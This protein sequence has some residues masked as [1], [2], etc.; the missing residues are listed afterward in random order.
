MAF[1]KAGLLQ[2]LPPG[3]AIQVEAGADA[4]AV[5]NVGGTLYAIDGICPHSGGPLGY[6][7]LDGAILSC[8]FHGWEFDCRTGAFG[9]NEDL[10]LATYP[11]KVEDGEI[12][13]E[14][15]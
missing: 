10:K 3:S 5:C 15:A 9:G 12:L 7:A 2:Q 6:G 8:P 11:V 13:V 4:V 14:L 1:V